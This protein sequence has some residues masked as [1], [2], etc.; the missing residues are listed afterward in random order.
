MHS[1][2]NLTAS[3]TALVAAARAWLAARLCFATLDSDALS[4]GLTI[5][6]FSA[7]SEPFMTQNTP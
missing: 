2:V 4:Q 1:A 3:S 5:V 6:Y 7:Q